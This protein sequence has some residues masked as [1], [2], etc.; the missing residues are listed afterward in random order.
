GRLPPHPHRAGERPHHPVHP[1]SGH[2]GRDRGVH[3]R[4]HRRHRPPCPSG[5]RSHGGHRRAPV[6]HHHGTGPGGALL[7][8]ARAFGPAGGDQ[9]GL[10]PPTS[11]AHY[12]GSRFEP[13]H[14]VRALRFTFGSRR[15]GT[16]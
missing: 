9:R 5:E 16:G 11:R 4:C 7:R 1:A 14:L 10:C 3:R 2:R 12:G 6:A 8:R 13:I 15:R